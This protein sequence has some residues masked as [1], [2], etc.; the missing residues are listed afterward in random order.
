[1]TAVDEVN[2]SLASKCMEFC[3]ALASQ[4]Q[5]FSFSIVIGPN[6]SF[7]LDTRSKAVNSQ[8]QKKKASPSTLWRNA[9]RRE[10]FLARKQRTS[11][12]T[13]S[14]GDEIASVTPKYDQCEYI[15]ASEKGLKQHTRMKHKNATPLQSTPMIPIFRN[16]ENFPKI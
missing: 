1:M 7:S 3:Q 5:A 2:S 8:S 13:E 6:F 16:Y 11:P 14:I 12:T 4:G 10:E 9:K 15:A